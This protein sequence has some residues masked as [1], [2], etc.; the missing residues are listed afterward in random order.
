MVAIR[1]IG[2]RARSD[3]RMVAQFRRVWGEVRG[4]ALEARSSLA[5]RQ[6]LTLDL[7]SATV[8][9]LLATGLEAGHWPAASVPV[10]LVGYVL[11]VLAYSEASIR[12]SRRGRT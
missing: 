9:G 6:R 11:W 7:G 12:A 2:S 8:F 3:V 10:T 4:T 5:P 1:R